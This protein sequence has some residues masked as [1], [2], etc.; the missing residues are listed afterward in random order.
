MPV[1][2]WKFAVTPPL[3]SGPGI[4]ES[5]RGPPILKSRRSDAQVL[6]IRRNINRF[7]QRRFRLQPNQADGKP[8]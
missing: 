5:I 1:P 7:S 3:L 4:C 8:N 2:E 6:S